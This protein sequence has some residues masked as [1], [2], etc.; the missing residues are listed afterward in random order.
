MSTLSDPNS[1][2]PLVTLLSY[3]LPQ[4]HVLVDSGSTHCFINLQ[5]A[6]QHSLPV[7]TIDPVTLQ[8]F[9]GT[10]NFVITQAIDLS[11]VFPTGDVTPHELLSGP[12]GF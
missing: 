8:L 2:I 12:V 11:I 10:S 1:L 6:T 9:D 5:F 3:P 7:H 4:L